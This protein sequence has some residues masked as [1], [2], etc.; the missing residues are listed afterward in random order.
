MKILCYCGVSGDF[1]HRWMSSPVT[2]L[3]SICFLFSPCF[4]HDLDKFDFSLHAGSEEY[5]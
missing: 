4:H 1:S 3:L 2:K 5:L